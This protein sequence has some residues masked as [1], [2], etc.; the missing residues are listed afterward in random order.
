MKHFVRNRTIGSY[1]DS[2]G[3]SDSKLK[4]HKEKLNSSPGRTLSEHVYCKIK[5]KLGNVIA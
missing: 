3:A 1:F 5:F 2:D 4:M